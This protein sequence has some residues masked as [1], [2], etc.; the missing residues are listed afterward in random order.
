MGREEEWSTQHVFASRVKKP[1]VYYD[2]VL[3]GPWS[4]YMLLMCTLSSG[5]RTADSGQGV[6]VVCHPMPRVT[7]INLWH[8]QYVNSELW[9]P[10]EYVL[11]KPFSCRTVPKWQYYRVKISENCLMTFRY[12]TDGQGGETLLL[13]LRRNFEGGR[14]C[15]LN[16]VLYT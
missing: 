9:K 3:R 14:W 4:V 5:Q 11:L 13:F 15:I 1:I 10:P 2:E 7:R 6:A 8:G 12:R 16:F